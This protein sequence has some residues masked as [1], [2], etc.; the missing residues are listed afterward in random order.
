MTGL[1]RDLN[2]PS[3]A[4][5]QLANSQ[6]VTRR[7]TNA[8][9]ETGTYTVEISPPPGMDVSVV[10]NSISLAPG[11]S[12]TF[13][14]TVTYLSG[15]LELWRFGS[16]SWRSDTHVVR[17]PIAVRPTSILAPDEI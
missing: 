11:Q 10:P 17:S 4:I 7:V 12:T 15:P 5:S 8:S 13:D 14:V 6:T 16:F 3:I 1:A 9:D 2:L